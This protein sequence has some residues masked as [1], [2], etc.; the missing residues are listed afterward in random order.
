[1]TENISIIVDEMPPFGGL[2]VI[3]L[4]FF[5]YILKINPKIPQFVNI[6]K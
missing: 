5:V 6:I 2:S 3:K 1:M 4:T